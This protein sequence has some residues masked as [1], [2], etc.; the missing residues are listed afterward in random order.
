[1]TKKT[2][3]ATCPNCGG[4][5]PE[6]ILERIRQDISLIVIVVRKE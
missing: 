1:M 2:K 6:R 5:L 3:F 4:K